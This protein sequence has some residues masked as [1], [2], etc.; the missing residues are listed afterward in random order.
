MCAQPPARSFGRTAF[1]PQPAHGSML[2]TSKFSGSAVAQQQSALPR[3]AAGAAVGAAVGMAD[4]E[5]RK[6]WM[7]FLRD[8]CLWHHADLLLKN[9]FDDMETLA[10]MSDD[11]VREL[12]IPAHDAVRLRKRLQQLRGVGIQL[13]S[14]HPVVAFLQ[15]SG[16]HQHAELLLKH[17]FDDMEAL[18]E[19]QEG[20]MRDLGIPRGHA[21]KLAKRLREHRS[22]APVAGPACLASAHQGTAATTRPHKTTRNLPQSLPESDCN[23]VERSWNRVQQL[24]SSCFGERLYRRTFALAPETMALFPPEVRHK[25]RDWTADEDGCEEGDLLES[26][27]LKKIF[28]KTVNAVGVAVAGLRQPCEMVPMLLRL[29]ARHV[30]Y[31]LREE[32]WKVLGDIF[33]PALEDCLQEE[34]TPEVKNAWNMVYGF[35]SAVMIQGFRGALPSGRASSAVSQSSYAE[36]ARLAHSEASAA[37]R[38]G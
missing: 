5:K 13:D 3:A 21:L 19:I 11:D 7:A 2:G 36:D 12:G 16:L 18:L 38:G 22:E 8:G 30:Q 27:A 26:P 23:A 29:G 33:V 24:G 4:F 32:Y 1:S 34:L 14:S 20:D 35:I 37:G 31:G 25:Y 28:G 6:E 10:E 15:D 9:G 17:G